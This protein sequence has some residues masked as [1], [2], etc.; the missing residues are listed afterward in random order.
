MLS[1]VLKSGRAVE[2]N[3]AIM[4]TFVTLRK[5]AVNYE[6]IM[7]KLHKMEQEYGEKFSMIFIMPWNAFSSQRTRPGKRSVTRKTKSKPHQ[8]HRVKKIAPR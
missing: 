5:M 3:I 4:R 8:T 7:K 6:E 1:S 2:V